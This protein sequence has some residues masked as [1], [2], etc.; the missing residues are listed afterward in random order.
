VSSGGEAISKQQQMQLSKHS[1]IYIAGH[2][3]VKPQLDWQT[4]YNLNTMFKEKVATHVAH[5]KKN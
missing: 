3:K 1:K 4:K 5:F 2:N